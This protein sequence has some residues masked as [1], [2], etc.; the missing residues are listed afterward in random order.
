MSIPP[1]QSWPEIDAETLW[2][3]L[4]AEEKRERILCAAGR[5]FSSEG[6]DSPMPM[7]A[8]AAGV[9][10]A[11]VY[12]Q[13]PS[14]YELLGALVIRRLEQIGAAAAQAIAAPGDR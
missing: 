6:L 9:G 11:S 7:V 12:R 8:A 14:K 3:S 2:R 10:V 5:T 1:T 4:T 13:F